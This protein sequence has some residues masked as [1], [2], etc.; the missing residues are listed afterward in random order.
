LKMDV[1]ERD[2]SIANLRTNI[3][4]ARMIIDTSFLYKRIQ[5]RVAVAL[6]DVLQYTLLKGR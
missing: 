1:R 6:L 4:K 5:K 3:Q 2:Y